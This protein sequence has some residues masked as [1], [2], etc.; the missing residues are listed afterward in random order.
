MPK[1][2]QQLTEK[3]IKQLVQGVAIGTHAVG[4]VPGLSLQIKNKDSISWI[5]RIMIDGQRRSIGLG[6]Y[7][8]V[9]LSDARQKAREVQR[10]ARNDS[11]DPITAKREKRAQQAAT[12]LK[13][14]SFAQVASEYIEKKSKEFKTA[15][16]VQKLT[17]QIETY[18]LPFIGKLP[19]GEIRIRHIMEMLTPIWETK[20]ETAN[21]VRIHV[22]KIFDR[23]IA[24]GLLETANP[25]DWDALK[26]ILPA[27]GKVSK[28]EHYAA[29]PVEQMPEFWQKLQT[30]EYMGAK[31]LQF[32]ILT[33]ARSGE[34]RGAKWSEIDFKARTWT[35][36]ADR[37]KAT[38]AHVVP[39]SDAAMTL[40]D[41]MPRECDYIFPSTKQTQLTDMTISKAPKRVGYDVTA[42]GF[43]STFK[44]WARQPK[45]YGHE[46]YA[47]ELS[48]LA[49]A[50]VN[51]DSTRAAYA[52]DQ[53]LNERR[54]MMQ[55]FADYC[56]GWCSID[57]KTNHRS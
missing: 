41:A 38:K 24:L 54:P 30:L 12:K 42:H 7:S 20:T 57:N 40:L 22:K 18:A 37:M 44:D 15:K 36:P 26:E 33:A 52:R 3:E 13:L 14:T 55:A 56:R 19:I 28:T 51:S 21:R 50:H 5:M 4:G 49:L 11:F 47:D 48:E 23:A 2:K 53:L 43:R 32:G 10:R 16:Q 34:I 45:E 29:L 9:K 31:A 25:A 6:S 35:V 17:N 27:P 46:Q 39:L 8:T 1:F